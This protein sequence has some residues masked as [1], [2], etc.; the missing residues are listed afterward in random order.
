[1][2]PSLRILSWRNGWGIRR[3]R[4]W[5]SRRAGRSFGCCGWLERRGGGRQRCHRRCRRGRNVGCGWAWRWSWRLH[6]GFARCA[7]DHGHGIGLRMPNRA[8]ATDGIRADD[9]ETWDV[10][11]DVGAAG[12]AGCDVIDLGEGAALLPANVD[13]FMGS[14][15]PQ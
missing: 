6:V 8:I 13:R 3:S 7:G 9:G 5:F 10:D 12:T 4:R 14:V 15:A 1:M 2:S 11:V